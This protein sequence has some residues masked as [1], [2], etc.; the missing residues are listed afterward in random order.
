MQVSHYRLPLSSHC[1]CLVLVSF[2][3]HCEATCL[4]TVSLLAGLSTNH[5]YAIVVS[6]SL[7]NYL[8]VC[9]LLI[10]IMPQCLPLVYFLVVLSW[11][12]LTVFVTMVVPL[13]LT[14]RR[15][16]CTSTRFGVP[17]MCLAF[18]SEWISRLHRSSSRFLY[19][20]RVMFFFT[21][22]S[23]HVSLFVSSSMGV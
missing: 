13:L 22:S 4:A 19:L 3:S 9:F 17:K 7:R 16:V 14:S 23:F 10:T 6:L 11:C 8:V 21:A 1:H 2:R 5:A 12:Y 18:Y 15:S 20:H